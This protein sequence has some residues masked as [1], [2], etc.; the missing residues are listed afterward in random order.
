MWSIAGTRTRAA[1]AAAL[2]GELRLSAF[3]PTP[4]PRIRVE[5]AIVEVLRA[6]DVPGDRASELDHVR[7]DAVDRAPTSPGTR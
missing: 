3:V 6:L 7:P 2:P 5:G 4:V 1:L